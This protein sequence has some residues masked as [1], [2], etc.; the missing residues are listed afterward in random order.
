ML[1]QRILEKRGHAVV[2]AR[3]GGKVLAHLR[4]E[5]FDCVIMDIQMPE[6]DG[7]EATVAI[8]ERERAEGGHLPII[9]VTAHALARDRERSF[10]IGADAYLS[11]PIDAEVLL[12]TLGH[13]TSLQGTDAECSLAALD[14]D[15]LL[16]RVEGDVAL[17]Q[18][19]V[20]AFLNKD[21]PALLRDI[22][23]A[24]TRGDC[25]AL[26]YAAYRLGDSLSSLTAGSAR[27]TA[28]TLEAMARDNQLA[29]ARHAHVALTRAIDQLKPRLSGLLTRA[30]TGD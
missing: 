21:C 4:D 26:E 12:R 10:E 1:V 6:M 20:E 8:R 13:V 25:A 14:A 29:G 18:E 11:K 23:A 15:T 28:L 19:M 2:V 24:I 3:T 16:A 17:L 7:W 22:E 9:V 30:A 27:E 5:R